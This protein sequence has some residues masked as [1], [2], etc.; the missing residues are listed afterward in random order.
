M[1]FARAVW[2]QCPRHAGTSWNSRKLTVAPA[3]IADEEVAHLI[4]THGAKQAVA[5]VL[6]V[7]YA[8]FQDRLVL[9]MG[10][11]AEPEGPV[12][13]LSVRFAKRPF[14]IGSSPPLRKK[15]PDAARDDIPATLAPADSALFG[16]D[17]VQCSL[18]KQ[19]A[20]QPRLKLPPHDSSVNLWGLVGQTYQ[21]ELAAAWSN[22]TQAFGEE[23]N[24]DPVFEQSLFWLV[25]GVKRCFY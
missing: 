7:A 11:S 20:R 23:A 16:A 18:D 5:M 14:G 24:Q 2:R 3:S 22:C 19:R 6:L 13:P 8:H 9:A 12:P 1:Q 4:A 21:P 10:L 15:L 17:E 25:T